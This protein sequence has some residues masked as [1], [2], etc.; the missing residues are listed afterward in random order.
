MSRCN[1]A[2]MLLLGITMMVSFQPAAYAESTTHVTVIVNDEPV[3]VNEPVFMDEGRIFVPVRMIIEALQA[4]MTWKQDTKQI[5][6]RTQS[7]DEILFTLGQKIVTLNGND[8]LMDVEPFVYEGQMY[9]PLRHVSEFLHTQVVWDEEQRTAFL[10]SVP[11]YIPEDEETVAEVSQTLNIDLELF[12]LRNNL[13]S[14]DLVV[15]ETQELKIV[16]PEMM[17]EEI[18]EETLELLA[19]IIYLE[20]GYEPFEGQVAVGNVILNRVAS[21]QF[22]NT[23]REVIYHPGQFSPVSSGEFETAVPSDT[24]YRAALEALSGTNYAGDALY[25]F[26]PRVTKHTF[27]TSKEVVV[28]IGNHRFIK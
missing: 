18:D 11:L 7:N 17:E 19:K 25:F 4:E 28:E 21:S 8:F 9:L 13:D 27:F 12:L 1:V 26:N 20:A 15:D 3:L 6:I 16:I 23:I 22:P 5:I 2:I 24:A 10:Y 14:E